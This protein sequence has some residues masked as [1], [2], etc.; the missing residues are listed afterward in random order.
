MGLI[1]R[2]LNV[3][4]VKSAERILV[5]PWAEGRAALPNLNYDTLAREGYGKNEL[6]FACVEELSTSAAEPR[7]MLRK[8]AEGE[9]L[10]DG[11]RL[12]DL[13]E[14]PNPFMDRFEF[15]ATV[16]MH[17][18]IAGNAYALIIRSAS[19]RPVELWLMRPDRVRIVPD[20]ETFIRRYE[21]NVGGGEVVEIP[22]EDVIHFRT[23]NPLDDFYG[24]PPLA[25]ASGRV[26]IDNYMKDFVKTFFERAG[27][28]AAV[29][30]T[31]GEMD[32]ALK[33]EIKERFGRDYGGRPGWHGLL[34]LDNA[35]ASFT[36]MTQSL[37]PSGLMVPQL[38]EINESRIGMCFQVPL[39][40]VG[41]RL[42]MSSSSY[43]NRKS[44][45]ESFWDETLAPMYKS[46]AG[47]VNLRLTPNFP[48]VKEVA[49]DLADVRALQEDIDKVH[50]RNRAD[51]QAGGISIEEFRAATGRSK[52]LG[53]GT[54]LIPTNL[55]A[56]P[57][58]DV[59]EQ[60]GVPEPE[61]VPAGL[62]DEDLEGGER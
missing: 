58:E 15:F 26:D 48:D 46:L 37:G 14:R 29:L 11:H 59:G 35:E 6:V 41:A 61:R 20:R 32:P 62:P 28:P 39:S 24:M 40:L 10:H 9:W 7:M 49:F 22:T 4:P 21:Y 47:Q 44:D 34:V 23:R 8:S 50:A 60:I 57:A 1:A 33:K 54:F 5:Q 2:A 17:R 16:I 51:M 19:G 55:E 42:G 56:V 18:S 53:D 13:L 38:D 27:V 45:R 25:P 36:P 30:S 12:L 3:A 52:E 43:A 31:K